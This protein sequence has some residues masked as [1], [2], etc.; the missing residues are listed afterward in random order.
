MRRYVWLAVTAAGAAIAATA[1]PS[2]GS[3]VHDSTPAYGPLGFTT[4]GM[5]PG[6]QYGEPSLTWAPDGRHAII[7]TPG[8]DSNGKGT[9]QYW[10]TADTGR[11]WK[12]SISDS[13]ASGGGDCN[14]DFTPDGTA[15]SAD[16][17]ITDSA[18]MASTDY[19]KTWKSVG[20]AGQQQ[21]RQWLAHS[22]DGGTEY[23][24]YH[25]FA[26]EAEWFAK[27]T[28]DRKTKTV[29]FAAQDCC[30]TAQS[31][32]Q[33]S[34]PGFAGTQA[35][36]SASLIDEG[37]NTFSGPI[38]VD[39]SDQSSKRLYVIYS[40]SDAQSNLNPDDGV[41]PYGPTRGVVVAYSGDGGQSWTS[42]YAAVAPPNPV[43]SQEPAMGAIFPWG[44]IDRAGT[45]YVVYNS[46]KGAKSDNYH[47][48]YVYSK[49]HGKTWSK[50]VKLDRLGINTGAAI[51]ATSDAAGKGQL[52]VGWYQTGNG[53]PSSTDRNVLWTPHVAQIRD[54]DT[55][56]PKVVEQALTA[57][58]NHRGGVCLEGILC[59][60]GP[61]S[62]DRSLLDFF[63]VKINPRSGLMGVAYADNG[64][65][66]PGY[67]YGEVIFAMQTRHPF[68][69]SGRH[70]SSAVLP[71]AV[72]PTLALARRRRRSAA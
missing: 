1:I 24:V 65:A 22:N 54:A 20:N 43:G 16:L 33:V 13:G 25:D 11:T 5:G 68:R 39:P 31:P 2:S 7:C 23:L 4:L 26:A 27:G 48:Y 55:A 51:Y 17:Q 18:I 53:T 59:G 69:R 60:I 8:G 61:G 47:Q 14:V 28:Y 15:I 62:S 64:G 6:P 46:T 19:G 3:S 71:L 34:A 50:P 36:G 67:R 9:V 57:L 52:A 63:Q 44:S 58:P 66:R 30:N 12:H 49:D 35:G 40:I 45:L 10:Y 56:H 41:P 32:D 70:A 37:G 38:L 72:L 42:H 21:D 29:S